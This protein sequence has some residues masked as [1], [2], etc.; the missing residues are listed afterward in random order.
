[1]EER[2]EAKRSEPQKNGTIPF[3]SR[4][5]HLKTEIP[6]GF[7]ESTP[8]RIEHPSEQTCTP[9]ANHQ[10]T[11]PPVKPVHVIRPLHRPPEAPGAVI[12]SKELP[13]G[14]TG[15]AAGGSTV[16]G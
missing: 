13:A 3:Q 2:T 9:T 16:L 10:N 12:A 14:G 1:M 7:L 8:L 5:I 11:S 15:V 6:Q 4:Q